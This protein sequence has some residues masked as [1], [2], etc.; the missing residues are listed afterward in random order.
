MNIC[1]GLPKQVAQERWKSHLPRSCLCWGWARVPQ[2][3]T[4]VPDIWVHLAGHTDQHRQ[5][6]KH[7]QRAPSCSFLWLIRMEAHPNMQPVQ[8]LSPSSSGLSVASYTRIC[9]CKQFSL[10]A[11]PV[12]WPCQQP[13]PSP[14]F[15][16]L[17]EPTHTPS[18]LS[19]IQLRL[20]SSQ[21]ISCHLNLQTHTSTQT[22]YADQ[23]IGM[24][25]K[26]DRPDIYLHKTSLFFL[27][28][29]AIFP[30]LLLPKLLWLPHLLPPLVLLLINPN[31]DS[32]MAAGQ[33]PPPLQLK[34]HFI[35]NAW[36]ESKAKTKRWRLVVALHGCARN[37]VSLVNNVWTRIPALTHSLNVA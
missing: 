25:R 3:H 2:R 10:T 9:T 12:L 16:S 6:T 17:P 29:P 14:T 24:A 37:T 18:G 28:Y 23:E 30:W 22:D 11:G 4:N 36:Q 31:N 7:S 27:S 33:W 13:I 8:L 15:C 34:A 21:S 32:H 35:R 26:T 20:N 1:Q 19:S 5:N